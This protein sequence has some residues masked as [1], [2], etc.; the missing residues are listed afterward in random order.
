V[1][2]FAYRERH[3]IG[4]LPSRG[5]STVLIPVLIGLAMCAALAVMYLASRALLKWVLDIE[6]AEGDEAVGDPTGATN[7]DAQPQA[8]L[9]V[10]QMQ[11]RYSTLMN[12]R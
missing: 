10:Y 11:R 7:A 3:R 1:C 8:K 5:I 6:A 2:N 4:V 9:T 12:H